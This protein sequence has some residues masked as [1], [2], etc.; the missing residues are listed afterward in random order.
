MFFKA[1]I[2][3][4]RSIKESKLTRLLQG[5]IN[6]KLG[7]T[8]MVVNIS[9]CKE[10]LNRETLTVSESKLTR[11]VQAYFNGRTSMV[12]NVSQSKVNINETRQAL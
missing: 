4:T 10:N 5:F 11:F 12:V 2:T 1:K 3:Y 7:W 9:Q 6:G 8:T